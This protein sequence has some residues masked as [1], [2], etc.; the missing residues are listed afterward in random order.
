MLVFF[1]LGS[2]GIIKQ[3]NML[4]EALMLST[5]LHHSFA[6]LRQFER[7]L[8]SLQ[9]LSMYFGTQMR[10]YYRKQKLKDV[11]NND[12][13]DLPALPLIPTTYM[14]CERGLE[15]WEERVPEILSS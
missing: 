9:Q 7:T 5:Q 8:L 1:D 14:Q 6:T 10:E 2:I 12:G 11:D 15:E 13:S 4:P 3:F